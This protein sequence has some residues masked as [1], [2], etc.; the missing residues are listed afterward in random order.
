MGGKEE[1]NETMNLDGLSQCRIDE[2]RVASIVD[3]SDLSEKDARAYLASLGK[4]IR[5]VREAGAK[6][7]VSER[8][9]LKHDES[10]FTIVEFFGYAKHFHGDGDPEGFAEAWLHHIHHNEHHWQHWIFPDGYTPDGADVENGVIAMPQAYALEM[11]AD[12]MGAS[13]AYTDSWD[14][15]DWLQK[16][17]MRIRLH[18]RT[19]EFVRQVL[20]S[21]GYFDLVYTTKFAHELENDSSG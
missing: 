16:N 14:M 7:G 12:W 3:G 17:M 15:T 9:L 1:G 5:Y 4:H 2:D 20:S 13:K 21:L 11:V 6:L 10:K 18:S 19:A 8:L